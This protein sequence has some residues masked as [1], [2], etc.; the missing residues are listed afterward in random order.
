MQVQEG[1]SLAETLRDRS[2]HQKIVAVVWGC[3]RGLIV[4]WGQLTIPAVLHD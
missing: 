2:L 3:K 1:D 4:Q